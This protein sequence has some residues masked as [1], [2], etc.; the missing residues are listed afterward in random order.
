MQVLYANSEFLSVSE[1]FS[2]FS[3][4]NGRGWFVWKGRASSWVTTPLSLPRL[5]R[6]PHGAQPKQWRADR[7]LDS[8]AWSEAV[9]GTLRGAVERIYRISVC[10]DATDLGRK[11]LNIT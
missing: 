9:R 6:P 1:R 11:W 3:G 5:C 2:F 10:G 4:L 8:A 7:P